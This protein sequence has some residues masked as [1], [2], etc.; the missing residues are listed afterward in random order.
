MILKTVR[1]MPQGGHMQQNLDAAYAAG[2]DEARPWSVVRDR[3]TGEYVFQQLKGDDGEARDHQ[4][5][6]ALHGCEDSV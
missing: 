3:E 2:L 6:H 4:P 5:H 1:I